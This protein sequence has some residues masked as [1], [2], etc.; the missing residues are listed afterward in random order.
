MSSDDL[1]NQKE[2]A[3]ILGRSV[4]A[5]SKALKEGRLEYQDPVRRLIF[6]PGLELRFANRTRRK[7]DNAKVEFDR[8]QEQQP[9]PTPVKVDY[10]GRLYQKFGYLVEGL[11]FSWKGREPTPQE[12]KLIVESIDELRSQVQDEGLR[13]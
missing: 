6:R 9:P 1:I 5:I 8:S 7:I 3:L 12:L 10:W 2:A 4:S 13:A 11:P